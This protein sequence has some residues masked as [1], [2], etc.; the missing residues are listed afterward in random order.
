[1]WTERAYIKSS[2]SDVGDQFGSS[3]SLSADGT[4][5]VVGAPSEQSAATGVNGDM[6]NNAVFQA[7]AAYV[8]TYSPAA[9]SAHEYLKAFESFAQLGFANACAV[10]GDGHTISVGAF[11]ES[12]NVPGF[13]RLGPPTGVSEPFSGAAFVFVK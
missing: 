6:A 2:N 3:L 8:F 9:W 7:G 13:D 5:L 11:R 1:M 12:T 10:S 4:T